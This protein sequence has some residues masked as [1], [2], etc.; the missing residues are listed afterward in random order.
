VVVEI[1][2]FVGFEDFVEEGVL[3]TRVVPD[4]AVV[5]LEDVVDKVSGRGFLHAECDD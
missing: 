4:E 1:G 3:G 2:V 5:L